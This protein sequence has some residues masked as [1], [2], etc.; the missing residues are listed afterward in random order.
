LEESLANDRATNAQLYLAL[1]DSYV[2]EGSYAQAEEVYEMGMKRFEQIG[3]MVGYL[4]TTL[5]YA[6]TLLLASLVLEGKGEQEG[7]QLLGLLIQEASNLLEWSKTPSAQ[8]PLQPEELM[9][10]EEIRIQAML[11]LS[12]VLRNWKGTS[13]HIANLL[14]GLP[15]FFKETQASPVFEANKELYTDFLHEASLRSYQQGPIKEHQA[16]LVSLERLY[17]VMSLPYKRARYRLDLA[18]L[19]VDKDPKSAGTEFARARRLFNRIRH[20]VGV[21]YS[22]EGEA[23]IH[24]AHAHHTEAEALLRQV[25]KIYDD[26]GTSPGNLSRTWQMLGNT[27]FLSGQPERAEKYFL[28]S[29]LRDSGCQDLRVRKFLWKPDLSSLLAKWRDEFQK[30]AFEFAGMSG[31]LTK[32]DLGKPGLEI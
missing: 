1:G 22:S 14:R 28:K 2:L 9:I 7:F 6:E 5:G 8:S 27:A 17:K 10:V 32:K 18:V 12:R 13:S 3:D 29:N 4:R 23:V 21:A 20:E 25:L 11:L 24:L 26:Y 16:Y 15:H 19:M 30:S 31:W